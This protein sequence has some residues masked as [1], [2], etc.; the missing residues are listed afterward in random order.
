VRENVLGSAGFQPAKAGIPAGVTSAEDSG[1]MPGSA[2]WKLALPGV[3]PAHAAHMLVP[4]DQPRGF[5]DK[6]L[7][8]FD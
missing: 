2:S 3:R 8:F 7:I 1:K 4:A 6:I 5:E